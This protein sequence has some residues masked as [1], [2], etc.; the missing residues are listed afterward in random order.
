M[1]ELF[2]LPFDHRSTFAKKLLGFDYP[3]EGEQAQTVINM[4]EIVFE[5][6][7]QVYHD[8]EKL[9]NS[10]AIL[11]DEEFGSGIIAQAK[12]LGV[13]FA[14]STEKSGQE[15]FTFEYDDYRDHLL[16]LLPTYA[17]ALVRYNPSRR[18]D[19]EVQLARLKELSD[20]CHEH[21]IGLMLEPLVA[22]EAEQFELMRQTM[23]QILEAEVSPDLW[24]LEGL[25]EASQW[26]QLDTLA[27]ADMIM[28]GRGESRK[29]VESWIKAAAESGVM[30]GF[31]IGRTIFLDA[32]RQ[33]R[34]EAITREEAVAK[35]AENYRYFI[36]LWQRS[37]K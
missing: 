21:Q 29:R 34:Q 17:K 19:N 1:R 36:D 8:E 3:V 4:K 20:F 13:K 2:I 9:Q 5:A 16:K 32:L 25:D 35:I 22:G 37:S 31:A 33:F 7:L 28:L 27:S 18:E 30:R 15:I 11:V 12:E 6:F 14:V 24:K 10:M 23:Q 26:Q